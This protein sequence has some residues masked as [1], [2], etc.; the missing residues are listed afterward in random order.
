MLRG[1]ED[2]FIGILNENIICIGAW[3][4]SILYINKRN[5]KTSY[6]RGFIKDIYSYSFKNDIWTKCCE[7]PIKPRQCGNSIIIGNKMYIY[8]GFSYLPLTINE[9]K[10]LN[11]NNLQLP[12]KTDIYSYQ[13]G[14]CI[15]YE[16]NILKYNKVPHMPYPLVGFGIVNYEKLKKIYFINGSIYDFKS[17]NVLIEYNNI[18]VG[19]TFYTMNYDENNNIIE[20]SVEYI[21]NFPGCQRMNAST[22]IINDYIYVISGSNTNISNTNKY[23]GYEEYTYNNVIDNWKYDIINNKWSK[24]ADFPIPMC[25]AS[26]VVYKNRYIIHIG[27]V[28]YNTSFINNKI[29]QTNTLQ[30]DKIFQYNDISTIENKFITVEST[31]NQYNWYFSNL[32]IIYDSIEDKYTISKDTIPININI[33]KLVIHNDSIYIVGG[34][35]NPI[36]LNDIYYG[37]C[38]SLMLKLDIIDT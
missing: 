4:S 27:G 2:H 3:Q 1:S 18:P 9:I 31:A 23:K 34:E 29:V 10:E 14:L 38:L 17:F 7:I 15:Y 21:N 32:I 33:P 13:D 5:K 16:N 28:K 25:H 30:Y 35:G 20:N 36:L 22:H 8:G 19:S 26:S 37:N 6:E 11:K 12:C 24:I